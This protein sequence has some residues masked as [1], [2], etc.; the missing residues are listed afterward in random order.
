MSLWL[1]ESWRM[2]FSGCFKGEVQCCP[3]MAGKAND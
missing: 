1:F 2:V 3:K